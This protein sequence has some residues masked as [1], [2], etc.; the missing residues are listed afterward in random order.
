MESWLVDEQ[1]P[2]PRWPSDSWMKKRLGFT[3]PK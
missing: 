1:G 2:E 3:L